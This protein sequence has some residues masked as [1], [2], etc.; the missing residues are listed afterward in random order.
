MFPIIFQSS[1]GLGK[2]RCDVPSG[3]IQRRF[4]PHNYKDPFIFTKVG[5]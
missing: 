1:T 3:T 5:L 4:H 2:L